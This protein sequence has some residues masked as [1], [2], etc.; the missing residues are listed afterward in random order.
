MRTTEKK[1]LT[2]ESPM[3]FGAHKG[4]KMKDVDAGYLLYLWNIGVWNQKGRP[5]HEYI[6][7]AMSA[8]EMDAPDV[9]VEHRP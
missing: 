1:I 2:D 4:E 8:L 9:I 7:N 6:K 3:P 5:V